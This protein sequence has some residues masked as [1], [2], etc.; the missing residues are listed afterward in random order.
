MNLQIIYEALFVGKK[1]GITF[2]D[3]KEVEAFRVKISKYKTAQD[4]SL[5]E[6]GVIEEKDVQSISIFKEVLTVGIY[7]TVSLSP[8][9]VFKDYPTAFILREEE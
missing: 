6:L 5:I 7:I 3:K 2:A 8:R 1:V 9:R 4:K